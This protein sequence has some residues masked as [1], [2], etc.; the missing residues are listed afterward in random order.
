MSSAETTESCPNCS[1]EMNLSTE[2]RPFTWVQGGCLN[3]GF[4]FFTVTT[5]YNLEE[6]NKMRKFAGKRPLTKLP[7]QDYVLCPGVDEVEDVPAIPSPS[8]Q[9]HTSQPVQ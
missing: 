4:D 7:N 2:N 5:Y 6:L 8:E 9:E 1:K 3:C